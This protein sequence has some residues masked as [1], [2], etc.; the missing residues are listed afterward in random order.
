MNPLVLL[1]THTFDEQVKTAYGALRRQSRAHEPL[2]LLDV[3]HGDIVT[4]APTLRFSGDRLR[5]MGFELYPEDRWAWFAGDYALY[6][7]FL[8]R[9][10][11]S[12]FLMIDYDTRINFS[13]DDF[14]RRVDDDGCDFVASYAGFESSDWM[15][16]TAGKHWFDRVAGCLFPIVLL[17][18]RLLVKCLERRLVHA[19]SIPAEKEQRQQF[20]RQRWMN[21]EA[22]VPSVALSEG[23]AIADIQKL[24]PGWSYSFMRDVDVLYW[25]MPQLADIPCAHPVFLKQDLPALVSRKLR[26]LPPGELR[27]WVI[28]RAKALRA[29][30][31]AVWDAVSAANK[32]LCD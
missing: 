13:V 30:D 22:F 11:S 2:L 25:D 24:V 9:P 16:T 12:H 6:C 14:L 28:E 7:A 18:R 19:R 23:Y 15:W 29:S 10:D 17:S 4:D 21:C 27:A 26:D 1:R 20:L 32:E 3:S 8:D 5:K 31:S